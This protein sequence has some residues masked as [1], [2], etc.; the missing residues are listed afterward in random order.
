MRIALACTL[1]Q[2]HALRMSTGSGGFLECPKQQPA[3]VDIDKA[4]ALNIATQQAV[5]TYSSLEGYST[6]VCE[7]AFFWRVFF[8]P[9]NAS[10]DSSGLEYIW[11][12]IL[13]RSLKK[14]NSRLFMDLCVE[15][16]NE[17]FPE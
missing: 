1:A 10:G 13:A 9:K 15:L 17:L 14:E 2:A 4:A 12:R 5:Q 3:N 6:V 7:Q 8:D 11:P 16:M